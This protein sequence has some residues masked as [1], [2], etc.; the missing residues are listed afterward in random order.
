MIVDFAKVEFGTRSFIDEFYNTFLKTKNASLSVELINVS[1]DIRSIFDT[2][3]HTRSKME[4]YSSTGSVVKFD[5]VAEVS[6]FLSRLI[7]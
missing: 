3:S 1:Y 5:N 7:L 6:G 2:V 4:R